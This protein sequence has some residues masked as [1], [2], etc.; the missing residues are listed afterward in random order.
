MYSLWVNEF[1]SLKLKD[2]LA[3][4][5]VISWSDVVINNLYYL[6]LSSLH[7]IPGP[8]LLWSHDAF[9][10]FVVSFVDM[11]FTS[12]NFKIELV[13]FKMGHFDTKF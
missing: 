2:I 3:Q 1:A 5:Y 9:L 4:M 6:P 10:V 11:M 7:S 12:D 8:N 13:T